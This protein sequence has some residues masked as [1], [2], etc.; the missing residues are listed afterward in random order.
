MTFKNIFKL[1]TVIVSTT[2]FS[3]NLILN[4]SPSITNKVIFL[5]FDGHVAVGTLWNSGNAVNALPSTASNAN[6]ILIWKRICEDYRPFD[7]NV[8]TDSL[9][10]N[11]APANQRIRIV[12]TPT[13]AWF[14]S[15][16][17]V[18]YLGSFNW[19][20]NPGTPCWVFEN[21]LGYNS[22]SMAEAASHEA[23]L[24]KYMF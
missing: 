15:A 8:T 9:R 3:Q 7:V 18:A 6:K 16:G 1:F 2:C 12:F 23:D 24:S 5:D 20:G 14:G 11:N 19:G 21:Q 13:S 17:G 22:K 10:F 4:G